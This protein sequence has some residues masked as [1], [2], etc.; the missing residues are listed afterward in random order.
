MQGL[1]SSVDPKPKTNWRPLIVRFLV[2]FAIAFPLFFGLFRFW[3]FRHTVRY[4]LFPWYEI[5][6]LREALLWSGLGAVG[7]AVIHCIKRASDP[8]DDDE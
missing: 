1:F 8:P 6:S 7:A 2:I 4:P 5:P 3:G